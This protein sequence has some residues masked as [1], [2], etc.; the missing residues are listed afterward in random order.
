[1]GLR[2]LAEVELE[3]AA[4]PLTAPDRA[5]VDQLCLGRDEFVAR[6]LVWPFLMIMM[7][8]LSNG[9]PEMRFAEG[10]ESR[11]ALGLGGPDKPLGK[12][13]QIRTPGRQEQWRHA[14]VPL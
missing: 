1:M 6:I 9:G 5:C 10:H 8:E 14:T 11:E 4:E 7:D 3:H 12:R 2:G 13:I